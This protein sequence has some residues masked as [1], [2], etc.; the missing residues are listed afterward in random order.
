MQVRRLRRAALSV[1]DAQAGLLFAEEK[2]N[3]RIL[4]AVLWKPMGF[5]QLCRFLVGISPT[6]WP[7]AWTG[8]RRWASST[9][10]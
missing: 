4:N 5:N 6:P 7:D 9:A 1:T 8:W 3:L 10:A 2:W